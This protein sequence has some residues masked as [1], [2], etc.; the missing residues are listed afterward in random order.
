MSESFFKFY[1]RSTYDSGMKKKKIMNG[2]ILFYEREKF[3][4]GYYEE[5]STFYFH[6]C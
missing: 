1:L 5:D 6:S 3:E 4:G 2:P